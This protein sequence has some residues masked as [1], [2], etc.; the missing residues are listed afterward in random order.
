MNILTVENPTLTFGGL[1][2]LA[3]LSLRWKGDR[4]PA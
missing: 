2:A 4:L 1:M 3:D